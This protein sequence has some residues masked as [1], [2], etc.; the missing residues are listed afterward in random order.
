MRLAA[1][2]HRPNE[3]RSRW[4]RAE[5]VLDMATGAGA[6]ALQCAGSLGRIAAGQSAD[7]VLYDLAKARWTPCNDPAQQLVFA[8][9]GDS[10]HTVL[11]AGRAVVD[12]GRV[13]GV[14]VDALLAEAR[15]ML[16]GIRE[17]NSALQAA[18]KALP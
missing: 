18:V 17:R 1:I 13:V 3:E 2:L 11:V 16:A 15:G 9:N 4:T 5:D 12:K 8:E 6:A 14:D 10:V 7:L